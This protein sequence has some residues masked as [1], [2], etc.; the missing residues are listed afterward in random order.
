MHYPLQG[1]CGLRG[2]QLG[3]KNRPGF[4][5]GATAE[6]NCRSFT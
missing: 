3:A 6:I 2:I 1:R 5:E 4:A